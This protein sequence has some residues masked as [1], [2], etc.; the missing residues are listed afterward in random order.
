[1]ILVLN[2]SPNSTVFSIVQFPGRAKI[3]LSGDPR[4][5]KSEAAETGD[6]QLSS[7]FCNSRK[8]NRSKNKQ[9]ITLCPADGN[10]TNGNEQQKLPMMLKF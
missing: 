5:S 4:N 1:M 7:R 8:E 10:H 2:Q 3:V 9:S 6:W